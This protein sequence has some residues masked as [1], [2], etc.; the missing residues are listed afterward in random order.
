MVNVPGYVLNLTPS[1]SILSYIGIPVFTCV[2][3]DAYRNWEY[4]SGST[5]L[6][7]TDNTD[8]DAPAPDS[9]PSYFINVRL[10]GMSEG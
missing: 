2:H 5:K 3:P 10:R 6:L 7:N 1:A 4:G 9:L 8:R